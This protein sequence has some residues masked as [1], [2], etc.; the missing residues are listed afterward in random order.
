[1]RHLTAFFLL[2]LF[3]A[4]AVHGTAAIPGD[5][6]AE[7]V[8]V[9]GPV[10]NWGGLLKS[11]SREADEPVHVVEPAASRTVWFRWTAPA[12][13]ILGLLIEVE[14]ASSDVLSRELSDLQ[15]QPARMGA[16]VYR[17][18]GSLRTLELL[19]GPD[20]LRHGGGATEVAVQSGRTYHVVLDGWDTGSVRISLHA[21]LRPPGAPAHD[22]L[23]SAEHLLAE[24]PDVY[25]SLAGA[26]VE[27]GEPGFGLW[28]E[29]VRVPCGGGFWET[30]SRICTFTWDERRG[31]QS[32]WYRWTPPS[33]GRYVAEAWMPNSAPLLAVYRSTIQQPSFASLEPLAVVTNGFNRSRVWP[34]TSPDPNVP[35][36]IDRLLEEATRVQCVFEAHAGESLWIQMDQLTLVSPP[37]D[38]FDEY[39][40]RLTGTNAMGRL[41]FWEPTPSLDQFS[42]PRPIGAH[43]EHHLA[44]PLA[45]L[46]AGE[47]PMPGGANG[48]LWWRWTATA[49]GDVEVESPLPC[50]VW[51]GEA[52]A[53]L[54]AV[55]LDVR[56]TEVRFVARF[57]ATAGVTYRFRTARTIHGGTGLLLATECPHNRIGGYAEVPS[58]G[59]PVTLLPGISTVEP[60]EPTPLDSFSGVLWC[61]WTPPR[62][63][64]FEFPSQGVFSQM[65]FFQG[66]RQGERLPLLS[67][68]GWVDVQNLDTVWIALEH[69]ERIQ[70]G[71]V[72]FGVAP[73][74]PNDAFAAATRIPVAA[75]SQPTWYGANFHASAEPG[76]PAHGGRPAHA[77]LWYALA[78]QESG[79]WELHLNGP[80]PCRAVVYDGSDLT[81]L[82][83]RGEWITGRIRPAPTAS[84]LKFEATA[85]ER[86]WLALDL[87]GIPAVADSPFHAAF[88]IQRSMTN[89]TPNDLPEGAL[90][91]TSAPLHGT[92][93]GLAS[94]D[95]P[96]PDWGPV[97]SS[98]WYRAEQPPGVPA[99]VRLTPGGQSPE[100]WNPQIRIFHRDEASA[101]DL[102]GQSAITTGRGPVIATLAPGRRSPTLWIQVLAPPGPEVG[103][104]LELFPG[105][106]PMAPMPDQRLLRI[107]TNTLSVRGIPTWAGRLE[108]STNLIH[109]SSAGDF[110]LGELNVGLRVP[111]S[112]H[113]LPWFYRTRSLPGSTP[114]VDP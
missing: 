64:I 60:G 84:I 109:W 41:R 72:H 52:I 59:R 80:T 10:W 54:H 87:D 86:L 29:P 28:R 112:T 57:Q 97:G 26:G 38:E 24:L 61:R 8:E 73:A 62:R 30:E 95:E 79:S 34:P 55:P 89:D 20:R 68:H 46:E 88:S 91:L 104:T 94:G 82:R 110:V 40:T 71:R 23:A 74:E 105:A 77:S 27:E 100:G 35:P 92:T 102:I 47:P 16:V 3:A 15:A 56:S 13:G 96:L 50:D 51:I 36:R 78:I 25:T 7:P 18:T 113:G 4:G 39:P 21:F 106:L 90:L 70:P 114:P 83:T 45:S 12:D 33:D 42:R 98:I 99:W 81:A 53:S 2:L 14:S 32:V 6:F 37:P 17:S 43:Q 48:S 22:R 111:D 101:W 107:S 66:T 58:E 75:S 93:R 44:V 69:W 11:A 19:A 85:G 108:R 9:S 67:A 63:G 1:M 65:H 31:G 76:E 49:S 5:R 103:F